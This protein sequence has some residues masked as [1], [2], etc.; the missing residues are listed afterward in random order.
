M[1]ED[2]YCLVADWVTGVHLEHPIL[3]MQLEYFINAERD[4]KKTQPLFMS[5]D[6]L[7]SFIT[8]LQQRLETLK[9]IHLNP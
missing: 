3:L 8:A 2:Q 4:I 1:T 7:E 6:Q 9:A 5:I